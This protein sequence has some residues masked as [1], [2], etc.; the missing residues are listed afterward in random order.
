MEKVYVRNVP[1]EERMQITFEYAVKLPGGQEFPPRTYNL[2]RLLTEDLGTALRRLGINLLGI[3]TKKIGKKKKKLKSE[4][5]KQ[6]LDDE[7]TNLTDSLCLSNSTTGQTID[8]T[9]PN[10]D[11]WVEENELVIGETKFPILVNAPT[12][13]KANLPKNI[14][15]GFPVY[16]MLDIEFADLTK[17]YF[18]WFGEKGSSNAEEEQSDQKKSSENLKKNEAA[19][20]G[21]VS[22]KRVRMDSE[23]RKTQWDELHVGYYFLPS[24]KEIG[25][26]LKFVCIPSDGKYDGREFAVE[27]EN[28]VSTGPGRCPFENRHIF[29][30][31]PAGEQQSV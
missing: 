4:E 27:S 21:S 7:A 28:A 11:A 16:P 9:I 1:G 5:E 22:R 6:Q 2:N 10:S 26:Q 24:N 23:S 31:K 17:C 12:I 25:K 18:K 8:I 19:A 13:L 14:M 30:Q 20:K 29:T 3:I 15:A